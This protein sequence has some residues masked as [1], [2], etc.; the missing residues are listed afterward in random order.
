MSKKF[1]ITLVVLFIL[2]VAI[3]VGASM[4]RSA[5]CTGYLNNQQQCVAVP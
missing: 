1:W 2:F 3:P 4:I 5:N